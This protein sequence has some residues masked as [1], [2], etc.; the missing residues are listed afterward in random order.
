MKLNLRPNE[1]RFLIFSR[2]DSKQN[3]AVTRGMENVRVKCREKTRMFC[4][5]RQFDSLL[6]IELDGLKLAKV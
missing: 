2:E 3:S 6:Q 4:L 1:T 5:K